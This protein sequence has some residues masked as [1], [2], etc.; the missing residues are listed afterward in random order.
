MA[1]KILSSNY[2][3]DPSRGLVILEGNILRE[4]LLIITNVTKN[5]IIYNFS[6][7]SYTL[8]T[9]PV[10]YSDTN[11]TYLY[12]SA[13][14]SSQS[15][16]DRLQI[17]I[18][19]EFTNFA[20]EDTFLDPVSKLRISAPENLID[21]DFEYGLQSSK[22]ETL[23]LVNNV[24][25]FYSRSGDSPI[26][27]TAIS[28]SQNSEKVSVYLNPE[29]EPFNIVPG[30]P[31]EISNLADSKYEGSFLV[32]SIDSDTRSFTYSV[33]FKAAYNL[34]LLTIYSTVIPG[35]FYT[36]SSLKT[37]EISSDALNP[38]TLNIETI[39]PHGFISNTGIGTTSIV[40]ANEFYLTNTVGT[41][42]I[43]FEPVDV[44]GHEDLN[45]P[46]SVGFGTTTIT[47]NSVNSGSSV[48]QTN[49]FY[50]LDSTTYNNVK[51]INAM[52]WHGPFSVANGVVAPASGSILGNTTQFERLL[53]VNNTT[54]N[55]INHTVALVNG[56][57]THL[58][59]GETLGTTPP[60]PSG[61]PVFVGIP[62]GNNRGGIGTFNV[63]QTVHQSGSSR[64]IALTASTSDFNIN[65]TTLTDVSG[66][67][68][69]NGPVRLIKA[70]KVTSYSSSDFMITCDETVDGLSAGQKVVLVPRFNG[71]KLALGAG[72]SY[73]S[74]PHT[75]N[76]YAALEGGPNVY[77]VNQQTGTSNQLRLSK[78]TAGAENWVKSA[79]VAL[80]TGSGVFDF[81]S[82]IA[83]VYIVPVS[84]PDDF[85]SSTNRLSNTI[86]FPSDHGL[87]TNDYVRYYQT[88]GLAIAPL[89]NGEYYHV[90]VIN[91]RKIRLKSKGHYRTSTNTTKEYINL[92]GYGV[93]YD[94]PTVTHSVERMQSNYQRETIQV[95]K[96][97]GLTN[98]GLIRY[99]RQNS[100]TGVTTTKN[101]SVA[102]LTSGV[103]YTVKTG[104]TA[105]SDPS[106]LKVRIAPQGTPT[107]ET[108]VFKDYYAGY[109]PLQTRFGAGAAGIP[110]GYGTNV[111]FAFTSSDAKSYATSNGNG[112]WSNP[113]LKWASADI[114]AGIGSTVIGIVYKKSWTNSHT[115][116]YTEFTPGDLIVWHDVPT[117]NAPYDNDWPN[118]IYQV[119]DVGYVSNGKSTW[120]KTLKAVYVRVP[121][122]KNSTAF[123]DFAQKFGANVKA[124]V[125]GDKIGNIYKCF[126]FVGIGNATQA[127]LKSDDRALD[128]VYKSSSTT[129][130]MISCQSSIEIPTIIRSS[131]ISSVNGNISVGQKLIVGLAGTGGL[132]ASLLKGEALINLDSV[133]GIRTGMT[134]TSDYWEEGVTVTRVGYGNTPTFIGLST[135]YGRQGQTVNIGVTTATVGLQTALKYADHKFVDG[136]RI[137]YNEDGTAGAVAFTGLT[138]NTNY[139]VV[140]RDK[141]WFG[142]AST[143]ENAINRN[144]DVSDKIVNVTDANTGSHFFTS[145]NIN[146]AIVGLGTVNISED[147]VLISDTYVTINGI[148]STTST[149]F[150]S[151][152]S[153]GDSI[154]G[155]TT[156][157]NGPGDIFEGIVDSVKSD[158]VLSLK[159]APVGYATG[160]NYLIKTNVYPKSNAVALH[161]PYDGGVKMQTGLSSSMIPNTSLVRQ[162]RR[163]FRYQSG[164]GIQCSIAINFNPPY[165]VDDLRSSSGIA[166]VTTKEEHGIIVGLTTYKIRVSEAENPTNA[167][168]NYN[169]VFE[170]IDTP[171]P[172]SFSYRLPVY[173]FTG[174]ATAGS[175]VVTG[176]TTFFRANIGVS[177]TDVLTGIG[178]TAI[179][180]LQ[181]GMRIRNLDYGVVDS[182]ILAVDKYPT[183]SGLDNTITIEPYV[184]L[185]L[186]GS[187]LTFEVMNILD[188]VSAGG[189]VTSLK[190][191]TGIS[192]N[193][194]VSTV[195]RYNRIITLSSPL[196]TAAGAGSSCD[197]FLT[198]SDSLNIARGFPKYN[199]EKWQDAKVR[200]GLFDFQNGIFFEYD[201]QD[202]YCVRRNSTQ[203]LAG[204][205]SIISG[206]NQVSGQNTKFNSQLTEGDFI[207]LRGQS[208]KV[209]QI[210]SDTNLYVQPFYRGATIGNVVATKTIDTRVRQKDWNI[211]KCDGKGKHGYKLDINKIQMVY[212]D[213]SWYGAGKVRFGFKDQNG[214]VRYVHQF[215]HNNKLTEAYLRSGN[216]PGRYEVETGNYP[217]L[218]PSLFHW[219]TSVI[220]DGRFDDDKA[221]LFTADSNTL[222]FAATQTQFSGYL[223]KNAY[224][225][226]NLNDWRIEITNLT[227]VTGI[228]SARVGAEI[229]SKTY[230]TLL[231]SGTT[232]RSASSDFKTI[233][234]S[235][236][237]TTHVSGSLQ[238]LVGGGNVDIASLSPIPLV[239]IRLAPSVDSGL[240]GNLGYRD[241]INRMQLILRSAGVLVTHDCQVSLILN[242]QLSNDEFA[243]VQQPSLSQLYKHRVS[244]K[245]TNGTIVYSFRASGGAIIDTTTKKRSYGETSVTLD[246]LAVL[247]NSI[248]GG[249]Q[250]FPNGPDILTVAVTPVD[251]SEITST[252]PFSAQA[253]ITWTESQ[254]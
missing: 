99:E 103:F 80:T 242:G 79:G 28:V 98:N 122:W 96:D 163:Y 117:G 70:F 60:F 152:F 214:E 219:G 181:P 183:N 30:T 199:H 90:E 8:A 39:S 9:E 29:L 140:I 20:P 222:T 78:T 108:Y 132:A 235:Q 239:S 190:T 182:Q 250:V 104:L 77:Y 174:I 86:E 202:L 68:H 175:N 7:P 42:K 238:W 35:S 50:N 207:I 116:R 59:F 248:L 62:T 46:S 137:K 123:Y 167:H 173:N 16:T 150:L 192:S 142:L 159:Q 91:S 112:G 92:T 204:T 38:S 188:F 154:V 136:I 213:Y 1:K 100:T 193:I 17:F 109:Y 148:N 37:K 66:I 211:D 145:S 107:F 124:G 63:L 58:D 52:N 10:Y 85:T 195:D 43:N 95:P 147:S 3:F 24:P 48:R 67:T 179:N 230:P 73:A 212:M 127:L 232:I 27:I 83:S 89:V 185:G 184:G 114:S 245:I 51:F 101:G 171:T 119:T 12:L 216:L 126:D 118:D 247:G 120:D 49:S 221:Y 47:L 224:S 125:R 71:R 187:N 26:T 149:N 44:Y 40:S 32:E 186:T 240:T 180:L 196:P 22:W 157:P 194:T 220:M 31:V 129:T 253:R 41:K 134:I 252:S 5:I 143:Y 146:G 200:C 88:G 244:D 94:T 141:D 82:T 4:K 197:F 97:S 33:G 23:E 65:T 72:V 69:H 177:R 64:V 21:T 156:L 172:N 191:S 111:G 36:G 236:Q 110:V 56:T 84:E 241:L 75:S 229:K 158:Y 209:V 166:T 164:K 34:N 210:D 170:V 19:E 218:N 246:E 25:T 251:T 227:T 18:E 198:S 205:V 106:K 203:Q 45:Y 54:I 237:P 226:S 217:S 231:Q 176:I 223:N 206:S 165:D 87:L 131:G 249:E 128:G 113:L 234:L 139:F 76:F 189:I 254:A 115:D 61:S 13:N 168:V 228:T 74:E 169:G 102:E 57:N 135:G 81:S 144:S 53:F 121:T 138:S 151:F 14:V 6:D 155:F 11:Q 201:G 161:K 133:T 2:S 130:N 208:Y 233:Y 93:N 215:L 153:S 162:T 55:P 178:S 243:G 160:A 225:S 15:A 105:E